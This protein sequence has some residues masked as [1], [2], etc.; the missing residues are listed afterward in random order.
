MGS[1]LHTKDQG[2]RTKD[3]YGWLAAGV[4]T[5][6]AIG[7]APM[8]PLSGPSAMAQAPG[9]ELFAR[10]PRTPLELWEAAD[11]LIRT[12]QAKKAVPYLDRLQKSRPDDA[13]WV[14]IRDR[15]GPGSFLRLDDD[16]ATRPFAR[17]LVDALAVAAPR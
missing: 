4:A 17:P 11:Y 10:E 12:G 5:L 7:I 6:T 9:P 2:P 1:A 3:K 8:V 14:A 13:T 15:Y 16:P